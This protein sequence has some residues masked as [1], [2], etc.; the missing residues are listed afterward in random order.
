M[1][2]RG[3]VLVVGGTGSGK[4]TTLA[5]MIH[6]R[7]LTSKGHIITIEDPVEYVHHSKLSLVTHREVGVDTRSWHNAL[8]NTLRQ[9]PDVI[10]IGEIRDTETMELAIAFAETGH[11]C[12]ATLHANNAVQTMDRIINFFP[13]ERR[14]QLLMD[15]SV[16]LR[17]IISQ[18]LVRTIDGKGR[19]AAVE[20]LLNTPTI[21]ERIFKGEFQEIKG[22]MEQSKELGM[23]TFDAALLDLYDDGHISYEDALR[24]ADSANE[25]R[26]N[27]KLK[28]KR[29]EP[30]SASTMTF[31]LDH[32]PTPKDAAAVRT[33]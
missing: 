1:N 24:N 7:N 8:K 3:L 25:L 14:N 18:R 4:S 31:S 22:L 12:L 15:L 21:S 28:S 9:S 20:I 27:I 29:G 19:K 10:L 5:A 30:A 33:Q 13:E 32:T 26:L 23:L 6:H 17:S 11:L 16:N 2:K